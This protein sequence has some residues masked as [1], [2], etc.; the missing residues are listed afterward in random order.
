M[1]RALGRPPGFRFLKALGALREFFQGVR[2]QEGRPLLMLDPVLARS[3]N[4]GGEKCCHPSGGLVGAGRDD[5]DAD[6]PEGA[7]DFGHCQQKQIA[8]FTFFVADYVAEGGEGE[9]DGL[10][11]RILCK[12]GGQ[13]K[14]EIKQREKRKADHFHWIG[15][16]PFPGAKS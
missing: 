14:G 15:C 16:A 7:G 1:D 8:L 4:L 2:T 3:L 10:A 12:G 11:V 6:G 5:S 13:S 9:E